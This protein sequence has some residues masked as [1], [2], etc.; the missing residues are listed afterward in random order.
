MPFTPEWHANAIKFKRILWLRSSSM[1][2]L[3]FYFLKNGI[4][5][6]RVIYKIAA[7]LPLPLLALF[8]CFG[9]FSATLL[10]TRGVARIPAAAPAP[11]FSAV[12]SI[13]R[14][15][16]SFLKKAA[17]STVVV[18]SEGGGY[19]QLWQQ[20]VLQLSALFA[21]FRHLVFGPTPLLLSLWSIWGFNVVII[22]IFGGDQA[23]HIAAV[24]IFARCQLRGVMIL[25]VA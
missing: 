15:T 7:P 14:L 5:M 8:S 6:T 19:F 21:S 16:L 22:T 1:C 18:Q 23:G 20:L 3:P 11:V 24:I 2:T 13:R 9:F 17:K 4:F 12:A 25:R 10:A